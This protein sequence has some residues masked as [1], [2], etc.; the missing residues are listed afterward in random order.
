MFTQAQL[1]L[2][3]TAII[4]YIANGSYDPSLLSQLNQIKYI[5]NNVGIVDMETL[6]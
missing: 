1:Q 3:L 6:D 5:I 4:Y 2:I